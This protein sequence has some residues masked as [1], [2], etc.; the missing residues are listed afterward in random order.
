[1]PKPSFTLYA[2][3]NN[4][5]PQLLGSITSG[6]TALTLQSGHGSRLPTIYN[7]A[8]SSTGNG[9]TLN[10]TGDLGDVSVG[11]FIWN[12]TDDSYAIVLTAGT[13]QIK[14][15]PLRGGSDNTW[16]S[17]DTWIVNPIVCTLAKV[18]SGEITKSERVLATVHASASDNV[19]VERSFDGDTAQTFDDSDYL[20]IYVLEEH[21]EEMQKALRA[22]YMELE[23][24][25]NGAHNYAEDASNTDTYAFTLSPVPES[26]TAIDGR[27]LALGITNANTGAVTINVNSL[28]AKSL[29]KPDCSGGVTAM[30]ANDIS[31]NSIILVVWDD[32]NDQFII[33]SP[34]ALSA[35]ASALTV[36]AKTANYSVS[37]SNDIAKVF[38]NEGASDLV[39]FTLPAASSGL[40]FK[41]VV[42][43]AEYIT[44][45]V[46]SGDGIWVGGTQY[47]VG[48]RSNT[49]Y[50]EIEI[51]AIN[52]TQ[53]VV[54]EQ[55]GTWENIALTSFWIGGSS[56]ITAVYEWDFTA[57]T[58]SA[59]GTTM[60]AS[61][62]NGA[63][64]GD[65]TVGACIY[66][67]NVAFI[68]LFT[69]IT[70][71]G[72]N[73]IALSL[74][75]N[76]GACDATNGYALGGNDPEI[77]E[78][79]YVVWA[80]ETTGVYNNTLNAAV[81]NG[82]VVWDD[83]AA[84]LTNGGLNSSSGLQKWV[85]STQTGSSVTDT[86][87]Y[88]AKGFCGHVNNGT[89]TGY[90]AGGDIISGRST[91]ISEMIFLT[92]IASAVS[93][94]LDAG[95]QRQG[96]M[97][98]ITKGYFAGGDDSSNI[99]QDDIDDI[100]YSS[101]ASARVTDTLGSNERHMHGVNTFMVQ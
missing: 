62:A 71:T 58:S 73:A 92:E 96:G 6:Q 54:S 85:F 8:A 35:G 57:E 41:F 31:A 69:E 87:S 65:N 49:Q 68:H 43:A 37:A 14:T 1:M 34:V 10:D 39:R 67:T 89:T 52:G 9:R 21:V 59:S 72:A 76:R 64:S 17:G 38:S 80:D 74:S 16:T 22:L 3:L 42:A 40:N 24:T 70:W 79:H 81:G 101:G 18:V 94:T 86:L 75:Y 55:E 11:D 23:D 7:G 66:G 19:T 13:D 15:T 100:T 95:R 45:E 33:C 93:G 63:T 36:S 5:N 82:G 78:V 26:Y 12:K 91:V 46:A 25:Q 60:S 29:V 32:T 61:C 90:Y 30:E 27:V 20:Y 48:V 56:S 88:S 4:A 51:V 84:F 97:F 83:V 47:G 53:W 50:S 44:L 28:G 77:D 99:V 98:G 2:V